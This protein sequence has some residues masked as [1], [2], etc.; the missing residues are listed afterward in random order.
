LRI[1]LSRRKFSRVGKAPGIGFL[2]KIK[3]ANGCLF[4]YGRAIG[5]ELFVL[6]RILQS[7]IGPEEALN[8]LALLI[9]S[10]GKRKSNQEQ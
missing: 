7:H 8:K 1:E 3:C 5:D 9:L 2:L 4:V 10:A 6:C